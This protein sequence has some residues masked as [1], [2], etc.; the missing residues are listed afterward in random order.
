MES[1]ARIGQENEGHRQHAASE[2]K[3]EVLSSLETLS[4]SECVAL[5][6]LM[7]RGNP[8]FVERSDDIRGLLRKHVV[9]PI[10]DNHEIYAVRTDIWNAREQFINAHEDKENHRAVPLSRPYRRAEVAK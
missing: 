9:F 1:Q 4:D 8:Q 3:S 2:R 10:D 7:R 5:L 6:W